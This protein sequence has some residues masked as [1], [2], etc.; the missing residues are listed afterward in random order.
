MSSPVG[1]NQYGALQS[2]TL[3]SADD[4]KTADAG[5]RLRFGKD[6]LKE[7][8]YQAREM[9][10]TKAADLRE[11][12]MKDGV[13]ATAQ[14]QMQPAIDAVKHQVAGLTEKAT[15]ATEPGADVDDAT[16]DDDTAEG[17][18]TAAAGQWEEVKRRGGNQMAKAAD[19]V[20]SKLDASLSAAQRAQ[21]KQAGA[22][23]KQGAA[24]LEQRAE[25]WTN[26]L[27][28]VGVLSSARLRPAKAFIRRHNLQLPSVI[29]ASLVGLW[30]SLTLIR[31]VTSVS[32]PHAPAIDIHSP[33]ASTAWIK[34]HAGEYKDKALD[35]R[36]SL[37]DRAAAFLANHDYDAMRG[38]AIDYRQIGLSKLGL[39]EPTWGEWAW[40]KLTGR[41]ITWQERVQHVIDL[42]KQGVQRPD[43]LTRLGLRHEPT[44]QQKANGVVDS[45]K[46]HMPSMP[47][48]PS[49]HMPSMPNI[50]HKAEPASTLDN[51]K[52]SLADG[53]DTLR[54]HL[55][56]HADVDAAKARAYAATH[57]STLDNIKTTAEYVKNRIVHGSQE[58]AHR[59]QDAAQAA[60]DKARY[61][62]GA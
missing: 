52:A 45:I 48:M 4:G 58:A 34:Y 6:D 14:A 35:M 57:A 55:P 1:S 33:A 3:S 22:R 21:L 12:V 42:T 59:A 53:V 5:S 11:Q 31:L 37:T 16:L 39:A 36:A 40:A 50:L 30:L 32:H 2:P 56:G 47:S 18:A 7:Q 15:E 38:K 46:A 23:V 20:S 44:M 41:P 13:L 43:I 10:K 60:A 54:A 9:V 61:K 26:R 49:V 25:G 24:R 29:L 62:V 51:I 8:A 27:L 17:E 28:D 19:A